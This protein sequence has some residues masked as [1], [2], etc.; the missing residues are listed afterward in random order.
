MKVHLGISPL[1]SSLILL[2]GIVATVTLVAPALWAV[3]PTEHPHEHVISPSLPADTELP[4][5]EHREE[6]VNGSA[7]GF[8]CLNID[9]LE[10]FSPGDLGGSVGNDIW[11]WT[12]PLDGK[13]Y[14]LMGLNNGTAFVDI[15][16]PEDSVHLGTLPTHTSSSTWRDIKVYNNHAFIVSEA[17]GHGIQIFDLTLLRNVASPP[18][19][20]SNTAHYSGFGSAHNIVINEDSGFAYGVG[21]TTCNGGLS[22][23]DISDPLNPTDAGCFSSDGYTHDAQC[24]IYNGP[25]TEHQGSEICFGSNTDTLTIV[26]V[27][28][29]SNPVQLSRTGY[30][31]SAYTHQGWLT[32][33][34]VY[35]L[36]N[37]EIDE[38]SFGHETR[39]YIFD[40]SD[41]EA[42]TM[43]P[44][45][46]TNTATDHNLYIVGNYVYMANYRSGLRIFDI[47]DVANGNLAEVAFF[48]VVPGSD[49]N[50][51][52]GAWSVYP[53]FASSTVIVSSRE[54]GLFVLEPALCTAPA[55]PSA[56]T[57]S[58]AGDHQ[59]DLSWTAGEPGGTFSVYRSFGTCP[60]GEFELVASGLTGTTFSDSVSGQLDY[61]YMVTQS[62]DTGICESASTACSSAAT[63][64]VCNAPPAF[65]GLETITNLEES[66][67]TL[68]LDWSDGT[69]LC[70][71]T[72]SY[73]VYRGDSVDFV[74]G[75]GNRVAADLATTTF[76]DSSVDRSE[77]YF[78]IVRAVDSGSG[79]EDSN[80]N[81]V[82]A[83]PTGPAADG[84]WSTGAEISDPSV[85]YSTG[86]SFA[87]VSSVD[88][89]LKHIGW[90]P[91][92]ARANT[93]DRSYFSTYVDSQC[94]SVA[95]PPLMLSA[96]ESSE[97]S[98]W[99]AY[100][101][102]SGFD[103]GVIEITQ[104][105]G[106]TWTRVDLDGGY[107]GSFINSTDACGFATGSPA[108]TGTNLSFTEFTADLSAFNGELVQ[109]RWIFSTDGG[110]T[111]EGWYV[112]DIA[113]T[114]AEVAG[115]CIDGL[116]LDGF[117]SGSTSA[118]SSA[119]P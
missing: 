69:A 44:F 106:S 51:T 16:D 27:T 64:G 77:A 49:A 81:V 23:V 32:D 4:D 117:E 96:G 102:E 80:V 17:G 45:T 85:I 38:L 109:I 29:K 36:V 22:M 93:G 63:T 3:E 28:D 59:I 26:D 6:C 18:E 105:G 98:F 107:P 31:G 13:E 41:L 66:T 20:F 68:Q 87:A 71:G 75:A 24:V 50:G 34:H 90:E 42:P 94:I 101:I 86:T 84:T 108:I 67:C 70:G 82:E 5:P 19:T 43:T 57:A 39:T 55:D 30:A 58:G 95:T 89:A 8:P 113:I 65:A 111:M 116:F 110:L 112:D 91:S 73:N 104:D 53:F 118:W 119:I 40:V 115:S 83:I 9:L 2:L 97:M 7:D 103:G 92:D 48:D 114:H 37:D 12:D 21:A 79:T 76:T 10:L 47:S 100:D 35:H 11:G 61:S 46:S 1:R 62:D 88:P 52:S 99:T 25:D 72:V 74:P 14:A 54:G 33:D 15:S 78:Y 56:L 60:G